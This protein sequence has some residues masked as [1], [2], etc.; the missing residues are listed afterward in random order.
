MAR[1][2]DIMSITVAGTESVT[3]VKLTHAVKIVLIQ[4]PTQTRTLTQTLILVLSLTASLLL[5]DVNTILLR[6]MLADAL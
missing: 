6:L 1:R 4:I 2:A 5:R 3:V